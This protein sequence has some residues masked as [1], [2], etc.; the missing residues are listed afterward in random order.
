[1]N[2]K[3]ITFDS[4][5][6]AIEDFKKGKP[7]V[8]VDD[9]DRE[10][11][12]DLIIAG[13]LITTESM[14]FIIRN[15][16]GVVCVPMESED[17]DRLNLPPM[18]LVNEDK[19]GTAFSVSVDASVGITTGISAEDRAT[20]VKVLADRNSKPNDVRKP[21][22]VFPLRAAQGGVLRRAGHTEAGVDLAKLAGLNP[23]AVICELTEEDGSIRKYESS[24]RFAKENS[25]KFIS[26]ADLISYRRKNERQVELFSKSK[27]PTKYGDFTA[28][29]YKSNIDGISHI[30]LVTGEIGNGEDVLVRVHSECLTG[31]VLGSLRCDCGD[32][33]HLAMKVISEEGRGIILYVRGHEGRSIGLLNKIAAYG[34]QDKG[35]DTVE[36]NIELGLPAD[37]RDYGT[38]AQILV[39]LGVKTMRLL[40]NNPSKRAGLEGYGLKIVERVALLAKANANNVEYLSTKTNKMGHQIPKESLEA[41]NE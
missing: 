5:D 28:Y 11:E 24:Y 39:D 13:S 29:G 18:T 19:K 31:D 35:R 8:V 4:I 6:G 9:E 30:A 7:V 27:L 2:N 3:T 14:N 1:M 34:L 10:N 22:H 17:L 33:L 25:L 26:I 23:V 32:Q 40:T 20:T 15:T 37:A 16:S 38:G 21:G 41:E 36:A 12:G